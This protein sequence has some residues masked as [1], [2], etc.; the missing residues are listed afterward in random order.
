[1]EHPRT[2]HP[3]TGNKA[4]LGAS[5]FVAGSEWAMSLAVT[6]KP[7]SLFP[8]HTWLNMDRAPGSRALTNP[9]RNFRDFGV[10]EPG[11]ESFRVQALLQCGNKAREMWSLIYGQS[12]FQRDNE[13]LI[14]I[15]PPSPC[16]PCQPCQEARTR[17]GVNS[18]FPINV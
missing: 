7:C 11:N 10:T 1:M 4:I 16:T 5:V 9:R 13:N 6:G 17:L 12:S 3:G 14:A 18:P 2:F 8:F 15:Q